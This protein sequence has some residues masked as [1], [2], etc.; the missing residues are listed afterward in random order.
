MS[1][2]P[3]RRR[4]LARWIVGGTAVVAIG[5]IV[6]VALFWNTLVEGFHFRTLRRD[7]SLASEYAIAPEDSP[8]GR[9]IRRFISTPRGQRETTKIVVEHALDA[10]KGIKGSSTNSHIIYTTRRGGRPKSIVGSEFGDEVLA[11][12][13]TRSFVIYLGDFVSDG[14]DATLEL[15]VTVTRHV[16]GD[17]AYTTTIDDER[18]RALFGLL[19]DTSRSPTTL[20]LER[21][22]SLQFEVVPG[23]SQALEDFASSGT[24]SNEDMR[25]IVVRA[26]WNG[27]VV[28][29]L[30]EGLAS[31]EER[32]RTCSILALLQFPVGG[33]DLERMATSLIRTSSVL[34]R[35]PVH[36]KRAVPVLREA[37]KR[38]TA[39]QSFRRSACQTL[40]RIGPAALP[41]L[42]VLT[43][44]SSA[45]IRESAL[46]GISSL[47]EDGAEA[48]REVIGC[49]EDPDPILRSAA[50][51][52]L[53]Q[54]SSA[55]SR[56]AIDPLLTR[57]V[58]DEPSVRSA[59]IL[60]LA[61]IAPLD[62]RAVKKI[63][64]RLEDDDIGVRASAL[65]ALVTL[66][67]L[68]A[69]A[70]AALKRF[71]ETADLVDAVRASTLLDRILKDT[72]SESSTEERE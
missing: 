63:G 47:G 57:V 62:E 61:R 53:A 36:G 13:A 24:Q 44:N 35:L 59:A 17:L 34:Q 12:L 72:E 50:I 68:A 1:P 14:K 5:G 46:E 48:S 10:M 2:T 32:E 11:D 41:E 42:R 54:I 52:S 7:P 23:L 18:W 30:L 28:P 58:D 65:E 66:A 25:V 37:L 38:P 45:F 56:L 64:E 19:R 40:A 15:T 22:P 21:Y 26:R 60:A 27:S 33:E 31:G 4:E 3:R 8:E 6:L 55:G 39:P 71:S 51:R 49:L 43:K 67:K 20:E 70:R 9:A 69:P 16:D 29:R